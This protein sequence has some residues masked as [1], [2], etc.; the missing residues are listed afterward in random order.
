M[1]GAPALG[2]DEAGRDG[3]GGGF[4]P[5]FLASAKGAGEEGRGGGEGGGGGGGRRE[6]RRAG[7]AR[8]AGGARCAPSEQQR[9]GEVPPSAGLRPCPRVPLSV[10][11]SVWV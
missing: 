2:R 11:L 1:C 8:G 4:A 6:T 3:A 9:G 10:G 5:L 7:A